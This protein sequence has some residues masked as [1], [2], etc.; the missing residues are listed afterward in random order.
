MA[1]L[2]IS[3]L[4]SPSAALISVPSPTAL[5]AGVLQVTDQS[6]LV[7]NFWIT[8]FTETYADG[9]YYQDQGL[10]IEVIQNN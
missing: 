6:L 1:D 8:A 9:D 4:S 10:N 5:T 7:T 2:E 3:C